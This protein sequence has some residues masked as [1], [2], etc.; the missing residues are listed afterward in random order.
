FLIFTIF[1][2]KLLSEPSI[3]PANIWLSMYISS[4]YFITQ[5]SSFP[6][7]QS[8]FSDWRFSS[9]AFLRI[10]GLHIHAYSRNHHHLNRTDRRLNFYTNICFYIQS[11][12]PVS[13]VQL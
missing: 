11:D 2:E 13:Y 9:G 8:A 5:T 10:S 12:F 1:S 7:Y 4:G 6:A 3:S